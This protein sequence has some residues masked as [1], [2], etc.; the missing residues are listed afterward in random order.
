MKISKS[1]LVRIPIARIERNPHNPRELFDK[2][3]MDILKK[4]IKKVGVLVPLLVY[5]NKNNEGHFTIL[6]G[7]RR[8]RCTQE[9]YEETGDREFFAVPANVIDEPSIEQ[10]IL[11]M[12]N[13]HN[14][15]EEWELMPTAKKLEVLMESFHTKS[16]QELAK[17][18]G[19]TPAQVKRC[20]I[21]LSLPSK[22]QD[23]MLYPDPSKRIKADLFIE[24]YPIVNLIKKNFTPYSDRFTRN[25]LI[26]IFFEKY[27]NRIITN[28]LH[29]RK[30]ADVL[31]GTK[32]GFPKS[33]ALTI[34]KNILENPDIGIVDYSEIIREHSMVMSIKNSFEKLLPKFKMLDILDIGSNKE[35]W[36]LL[37]EFKKIIDEKLEDID[38]NKRSL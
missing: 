6:D 20:K 13:I 37:K 33:K 24:M 27:I 15:R 4:S 7:E 22:Y 17:L 11:T 23:M 18:T 9:L 34:L 29:F 3:P 5:E 35:L 26:E 32:H 30:L 14:V 1:R 8:W 21:L 12:F 19:L 36:K 28:V 16:E 2:S 31:R 10:N 38:K 25:K